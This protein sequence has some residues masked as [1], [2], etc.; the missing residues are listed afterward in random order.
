MAT[1]GNCLKPSAAESGLPMLTPERWQRLKALFEE[2]T[3]VDLD[4][5]DA[6]VAG[7]CSQDSELAQWLR[8]LLDHSSITGGF[9]DQP[10]GYL[11]PVENSSPSTS[12]FHAGQVLAKRFEVIRFLGKG[13][14]GEVYQAFD[15]ELQEE[16]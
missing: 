16:I 9:L 1:V 2:A 3:Q 10:A 11:L 5:R 4:K 8:K 12:A 6:F 15:R 14:M 13:G 7:A